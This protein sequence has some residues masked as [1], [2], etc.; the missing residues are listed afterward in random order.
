[1]IVPVDILQRLAAS[2]GAGRPP[3]PDLV[4]QLWQWLGPASA[5]ILRGEAADVVLGL[6]PH[7][8]GRSI[9]TAYRQTRLDTGL[10]AAFALATGTSQ[11]ARGEAVLDWWD[12]YNAGR[13]VPPGV[14]DA[15]RL[16]AESGLPV[17][18]DARSVS[19]ARD[20][21]TR[22]VTQAADCATFPLEA[23]PIAAHETRT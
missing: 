14:T 21:V 1:M 7:R 6:R 17:P 23:P 9:A 22:A 11:E 15:L 18:T 4:D 3:T 8:G 12:Q 13:D 2:W 19:R 20:R 5:A 16:V 10:A